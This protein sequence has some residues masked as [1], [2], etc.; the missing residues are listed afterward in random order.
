[1]LH[2]IIGHTLTFMHRLLMHLIFITL[3][4]M[5]QPPEQ[6]SEAAVEKQIS[7]ENSCA[8]VSFSQNSKPSD[9]QRY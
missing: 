4:I 3:T 9:L 5:T 2:H 7:Q 1:M 8:G 6:N